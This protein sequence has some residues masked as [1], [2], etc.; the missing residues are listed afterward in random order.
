M[1][2]P[3]RL[4]P[5]AL[6]ILFAAAA[7]AQDEAASSATEGKEEAAWEFNASLYGYFPPGERHYAQPTFI[8]NHGPLHLEARYNYEDFKTGSAW[9]GWNFGAGEELRLDATVMAGGL[10]GVTR[11]VAPGYE[12][13]L[14]YGKF[15]LYSEGEYVFDTQDSANNFFYNWAQ[16]GYSPLEWLSF[17]LASQRTRAY[18]TPLDVQRG[19]F[20]GF[21]YKSWTLTVYVFNVGWETPTVVSSLSV[22]F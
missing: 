8:A 7:S 20:V 15:E 6:F 13:T 10:F 12:L 2:A 16:L 19:P 9:V 5:A 17:G 22:S 4:A 18:Q 14:S 11:G 21:A 1:R 3:G